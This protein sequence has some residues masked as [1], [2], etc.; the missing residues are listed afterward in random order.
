M[1][2]EVRMEIAGCDD[3]VLDD[4][5]VPGNRLT[6]AM[7]YRTFVDLVDAQQRHTDLYLSGCGEPLLTPNVCDMVR[8][9]YRGGLW[10]SLSTNGSLLYRD[11]ADELVDAGLGQLH[12]LLDGRDLQ[13]YD[14]EADRQDLDRMGSILENLA[15]LSAA[16]RVARSELRV[17]ITYVV[18][19]QNVRL[20]PDIVALLGGIWISNI[21]VLSTYAPEVTRSAYAEARKVAEEYC[22]VLDLA[23]PQ[24]ASNLP[25]YDTDGLLCDAA[26]GVPLGA[27]VPA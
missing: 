2:A 4:N 19:R 15:G 24:P 11:R 20:L 13:G 18:T 12:V 8:Y 9:A 22:V 1:R 25:Y 16:R 5:R 27:A 23:P 17:Q 14:A 6:E 3:L 10:V 21:R 7:S 26:T